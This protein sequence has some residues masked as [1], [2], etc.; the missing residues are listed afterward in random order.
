M[1]LTPGLKPV[2]PAFESWWVRPGGATRVRVQAD[3]RLTVIDP[4]G[5]QP[6]EVVVLGDDPEALGFRADA[7]ATVLAGRGLVPD[8]ARAIKLFGTDGAPGARQELDARSACSL[9]VAAPGGRVVD[10]AWPA[11]AL[12]V[13][14]HRAEPPAREQAELPAPLAE[15]RLDFRVDH[16]NPVA[17]V[18][19]HD[20]RR[21]RPHPPRLV[22]AIDGPQAGD[23]GGSLAGGSR[24]RTPADAWLAGSSRHAFA[25]G[26]FASSLSA[27]SLSCFASSR[28]PAASSFLTSFSTT[29]RL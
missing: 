17:D 24:P 29:R 27:C 6:A 9:V 2:D 3:D 22:R 1:L 15:P 19:L 25:A 13:E 4:D 16:G 12:I 10:G 20:R 18:Q 23:E 21:A 28:L 11:S 26:S 5:G 8:D 14:L 7:P